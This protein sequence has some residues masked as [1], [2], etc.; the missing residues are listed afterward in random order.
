MTK[1]IITAILVAI[2]SSLSG[3]AIFTAVAM[4]HMHKKEIKALE[5]RH[6]LENDIKELK[7]KSE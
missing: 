4:D 2:L 7:R 5:E 3:C 1:F 6:A